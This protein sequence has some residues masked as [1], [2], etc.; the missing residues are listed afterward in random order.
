MDWQY[1]KFHLQHFEL[2][3]LARA[4]SAKYKNVIKPGKESHEEIYNPNIPCHGEVFVKLEKEINYG[5]TF[6]ITIESIA[7]FYL[8]NRAIFIK[9]GYKLDNF[10]GIQ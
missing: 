5:V 10:F 9:Q 2:V 1:L 3:G 7:D 6:T 4:V 8:E